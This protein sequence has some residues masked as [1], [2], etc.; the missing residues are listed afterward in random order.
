MT[1]KT[2][3]IFLALT[4]A[5]LFAIGCKDN[6]EQ[7]QRE[8]EV[9]KAERDSAFIAANSSSEEYN[10]LFNYITGIETALD[11]IATEE[12][13]IS[14]G[15]NI[16]EKPLTRIE[17][18]ERIKNFG[19]LLQRQRQYIQQLEDSLRGSPTSAS[20]L[21][22]IVSSLRQ[23]LENKD[24]QLA[25]MRTALNSSR[26]SMVQ[27]QEQFAQI[28]SSNQALEQQNQQLEQAVVQTNQAANLGWFTVASK[29]ELK[30]MGILTGGGF[31]KKDKINYGAFNPELFQEVDIRTFDSYRFNS[32]K[33]KLIT[34]APEGTYK[35]SK[36]GKDGWIFEILS[37]A[38]FWSVSN[39][40]IIQTD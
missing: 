22:T 21:L 2:L 7:Y 3:T 39:F 18:R 31:L 19:A 16:G 10:E 20:H 25:K 11:S 23:Q 36:D 6:T 35:L 24:Q 14:I 17:M 32:K 4:S 5:M 8:I 15:G 12:S 37:P 38:D 40:H 28:A 9:L 33:A 27:L 29:S 13:I 34:P 26:K 1:H 30:Q